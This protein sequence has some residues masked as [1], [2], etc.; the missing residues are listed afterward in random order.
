M[1]LYTTATAAIDRYTFTGTAANTLFLQFQRYMQVGDFFDGGA[2]TDKIQIRSSMAGEENFD[3]RGTT[4]RSFEQL[5]Y[6]PM[7]G[8]AMPGSVIFKSSQFGSDAQGHALI[9]NA[10]KVIGSNFDATDIQRI[11]VDMVAGD[12]KFDAHAWTFTGW[13]SSQDKI[14]VYGSSGANIIQGSIMADTITGAAGADTLRGHAG[15]DT[16]IGGAGRDVLTGDAGADVFDF[17][18]V[19]ETGKTATTRDLITD[20]A[21]LTDKIDLSSIDANGALSGNGTF[22][23]LATQ[24]AAFTGVK[25]QLHWFQQG[26][27]TFIEGDMDGNKAADFQIELSGLKPLTVVDFM[28]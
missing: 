13:M 19:N 24:G 20:F 11:R 14:T 27:K 5:S 17:N 23:F 2:G 16:I 3:V 1:A 6:Y 25:G 9:S 22:A 28:L 26:G 8:M 10:L 4:F 15:N 21:H 18:A 12:S 7:G